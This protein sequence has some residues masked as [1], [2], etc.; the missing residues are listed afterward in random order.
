VSGGSSP[1]EE[2]AE[3]LDPRSALAADESTMLRQSPSI[4]DVMQEIVAIAPGPAVGTP[5][6]ETRTSAAPR[7]QQ[8]EMAVFGSTEWD[9]EPGQSASGEGTKELVD[10][11]ISPMTPQSASASIGHAVA[12]DKDE[13]AGASLPLTPPASSKSQ[14]YAFTGEFHS[15]KSQQANSD[16]PGDDPPTSQVDDRA[17]PPPSSLL[18]QV[19]RPRLALELSWQNMLLPSVSVK[20]LSPQ[21]PSVSRSSTVSR[22][23]NDKAAA[24]VGHGLP[25]QATNNQRKLPTRRSSLRYAGDRALD[26]AGYGASLIPLQGPRNRLSSWM[27]SYYSA[28]AAEDEL[29]DRERSD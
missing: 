19:L 3:T 1:T 11:P 25:D 15:H 6:I 4:A 8:S 14:D 23:S 20:T 9:N 2:F 16:T 24:G 7:R 5:K 29:R 21:T 17:T 28:A 27:E 26:V 18:P 12:Y 10:T 13:Y 22:T